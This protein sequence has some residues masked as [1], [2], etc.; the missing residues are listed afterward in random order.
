MHM[1][2]RRVTDKVGVFTSKEDV[3]SYVIEHEYNNRTTRLDLMCAYLILARERNDEKTVERIAVDLTRENAT[4]RFV[5]SFTNRNFGRYGVDEFIPVYERLVLSDAYYPLLMGAFT[6]FKQIQWD[7]ILSSL[8]GEKK[9]TS[10]SFVN[11][12]LSTR[13]RSYYRSWILEEAKKDYPLLTERDLNIYIRIR[14][15]S[16]YKITL[17]NATNQEIVDLCKEKKI[18]G[19]SLSWD[20]VNK[21]RVAFGYESE[22]EEWLPL[23]ERPT[24]KR[25]H[26]NELRYLKTTNADLMDEDEMQDVLSRIR[27]VL[28][29]TDEEMAVLQTWLYR[30]KYQGVGS[31]EGIIVPDSLI[32]R[33]PRTA[34]TSPKTSDN[35]CAINL[36]RMA[37]RTAYRAGKLGSGCLILDVINRVMGSATAT[38][39]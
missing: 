29:Y 21:L 13:I 34:L 10:Q 30:A 23:R 3:I 4:C 26:P 22:N 11:H 28:G 2:T 33:Y 12:Y 25:E 6:E 9:Y 36:M 18:E 27:T 15:N 38:A 24:W 37:V 39:A 32:R 17:S 7:F 31:N 16:D 20:R 5:M 14:K 1:T 35:A 8:C 19:G